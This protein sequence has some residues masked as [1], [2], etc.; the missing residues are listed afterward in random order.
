MNVLL[1]NVL[2]LEIRFINLLLTLAS[3]AAA[4]PPNPGSVTVF[5]HPTIFIYISFPYSYPICSIPISKVLFF[6]GVV[7]GEKHTAREKPVLGEDCYG[8]YE[9]DGNWI[10][11]VSDVL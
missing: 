4:A 9:E 7:G 3:P 2:T 1:I 8:V 6:V 11:S 5:D 10:D